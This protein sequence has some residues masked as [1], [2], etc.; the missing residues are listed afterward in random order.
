MEKKLGRLSKSMECVLN[1]P[2]GVKE[3]MAFIRRTA[4]LKGT[5]SD[6]PHVL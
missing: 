4:R 2:E 5:Y 6:V 3:L 1:T